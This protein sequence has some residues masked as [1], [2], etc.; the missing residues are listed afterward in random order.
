[1]DRINAR[2]AY[3]HLSENKGMCCLRNHS[4]LFSSWFCGLPLWAPWKESY[5]KPRQRIKKQRHRFSEKSPYSQSYG[6]S[7]SHVQMWE[8]DHKEGWAPKNWCFWTLV[9]D[10][11]LQSP[12]NSK[13]IKPVNPQFSSVAQSCPTLSDSRDYSIPGSSVLHYLLDFAQIYVHWVSDPV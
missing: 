7:S 13:E 11:T 10:K 9:L 3:S 2:A 12:L 8:L 4:K 6:F 5:D 1:M